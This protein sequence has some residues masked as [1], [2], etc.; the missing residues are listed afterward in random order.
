MN[1]YLIPYFFLTWG[2]CPIS[3]FCGRLILPYPAGSRT[4][5]LHP[6]KVSHA[7]SPWQKMRA[8]GPPLILLTP[9]LHLRIFASP[10]LSPPSPP[11]LFKLLRFH[12]SIAKITSMA[13]TTTAAASASDGKH[14]SSDWFSVPELRLRDHRFTVPL[15]Y[16]LDDSTSPK[17]S[18]FVRELVAGNK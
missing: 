17:I 8:I 14:V 3:A 5:S 10:T 15:D 7:L 13:G 11:P 12:Y 2:Y 18:V 1:L 16:S 9:L 4:Q 6:P